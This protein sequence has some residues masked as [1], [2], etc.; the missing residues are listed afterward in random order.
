MQLVLVCLDRYLSIAIQQ[1]RVGET[2]EIRTP[3]ITYGIHFYSQQVT[4]MDGTKF[5][6][7][8]RALNLILFHLIEKMFKKDKIIGQNV[9]A[10]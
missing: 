1:S 10:I 3:L 5:N 6:F 2:C 4:I 9:R 7:N 8:K